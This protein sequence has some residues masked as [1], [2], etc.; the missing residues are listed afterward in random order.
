MLKSWAPIAK[1]V[2]ALHPMVVAGQMLETA[3]SPTRIATEGNT[4]AFALA[5]MMLALS[6]LALSAII[7]RYVLRIT[8]RPPEWMPAVLLML[9]A[10]M[11]GV[12]VIV[13]SSPGASVSLIAR[14][15]CEMAALLIAS[16][17][18]QRELE[19]TRDAC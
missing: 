10:M 11:G 12:T 17:L 5:L 14:Y 4:S 8:D 9:G 19:I 6:T 18:T 1:L 7:A 3:A 2:V 15:I 16:H 13:I